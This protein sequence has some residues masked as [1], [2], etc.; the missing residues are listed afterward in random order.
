LSSP[1]PPAGEWL[2][3][4]GIQETSG[5]VARYYRADVGRNLPV[6]TE[7]TG[8]TVS[9]CVYLHSVTGCEVFLERA[10]RAARFLTRAAW[11]PNA[12]VLPFEIDP[13]AFAYFFDCGIVV[14]G[15][16]AAWRA[17]GDQECLDTAVAVGRHMTGDFRAADG[18][19]H[20]VLMLPSK[21]PL[22]R[23]PLRWS[24]SEGCYQLKA[25]M[26]WWDLA[27]ATGDESFRE[28]YEQALD[29]A[30]AT[31][32]DFL[33]GHPNRCHV[34]DRLHP[35]LYFLEGLLPAIDQPRCAAALAEGIERTARYRNEL[36][37]EFVRSDVY[38]QLL[39]IR[40]FADQAGVAR[41]DYATA[42]CEARCLAEFQTAG[43]GFYFGRKD[44]AFLPHVN[45]V[46]AVF[47]LQAL[48]MWR[49]VSAGDPAA[50]SLDRRMLI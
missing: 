21:D 25:A 46:S 5:G 36:A 47:A 19:L 7:I 42:D 24:Q 30:L 9:A 23:D 49:S 1:I 13:P 12:G 39:R 31:A 38:A 43:G 37:A 14:R 33:P 18:S 45:P 6:S 20:P 29:R 2:L 16:L 22:A 27:E 35:F 40:L 34:M 50:F 48:E 11:E 8:Y 44:G 17:A 26:A 28:P 32:P 41:L 15:L 10:L 3:G 4:S